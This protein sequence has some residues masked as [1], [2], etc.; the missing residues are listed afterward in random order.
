MKTRH[1]DECRHL[2][3]VALNYQCAKGHK[4]KM[5]RHPDP[6]ILF[7]IKRKCADYAPNNQHEVPK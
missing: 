4:P 5:Y 2:T 6:H 7:E 1:C 3:W